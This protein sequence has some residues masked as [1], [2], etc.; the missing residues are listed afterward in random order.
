MDE[1]SL[2]HSKPTF[3]PHSAYQKFKR[4]Y[5][6]E[7]VDKNLKI[8]DV[9]SGAGIMGQDLKEFGHQTINL[10][11]FGS[12][13]DF[14]ECD[15]NKKWPVSDQDFDYLVCLDVA[16]HLYDPVHILTEARRVLKPG[17][18]L[19]FGVPNHFDL[20]QRLRMLFGRGIIH[21]D[22]VKYAEQPWNYVHIRFFDLASLLKMFDLE[23]WQPEFIQ[24]NFQAGGIIPTKITPK[25]LRILFLKVWPGLF[26]GKF[27]FGLSANKEPAETSEKPIN[28]YLAKTPKEF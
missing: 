12:G 18:K 4:I 25:F 13:P 8:L 21:W 20:R 19:V 14:I 15:I 9:G 5:D 27:I 17:G 3:R 26:S 23:G 7:K 2:H 16:E 1:T 28:I 6:L 22:N 11:T 10:D 24:F